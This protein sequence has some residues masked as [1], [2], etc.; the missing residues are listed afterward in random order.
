MAPGTVR[1]RARRGRCR[2]RRRGSRVA[3]IWEARSSAAVMGYCARYAMA[4]SAPRR[5]GPAARR[6]Q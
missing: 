4:S 5:S 3:P 1:V 2:T 6:L